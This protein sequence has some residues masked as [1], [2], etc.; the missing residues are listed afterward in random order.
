MIFTN[1]EQKEIWTT[2]KTIEEI[3]CNLISAKR[4][5]GL[6]KYEEMAR[7]LLYKIPLY[8]DPKTGDHQPPAFIIDLENFSEKV[9]EEMVDS[10]DKEIS[11]SIVIEAVSQL[12]ENLGPKERDYFIKN[13]RH[14]L[15][16]RFV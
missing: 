13:V 1:K 16:V 2:N 9:K 5:D 11:K 3:H 6:R 15:I 10:Y 12:F 4:E 14:L 7:D 8:R